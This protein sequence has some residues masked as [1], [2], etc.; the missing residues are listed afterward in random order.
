MIILSDFWMTRRKQQ[1]N[2][3]FWY[4]MTTLHFGTKQEQY[5]LIQN[6]ECHCMLTS[7]TTNLHLI[8][9]SEEAPRQDNVLIFLK[10][11]RD[12]YRTSAINST[13][14]AI[15]LN[16]SE[17]HVCITTMANIKSDR[18]SSPASLNYECRAEPNEQCVG[19]EQCVHRIY[20]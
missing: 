19:N 10:I 2:T 15:Y 11:S 6:G 3:Y 14:H 1:N 8:T 20:R 9:I 18:E 4:K 16:S 12:L 13:V 7:H 5:I 17:H